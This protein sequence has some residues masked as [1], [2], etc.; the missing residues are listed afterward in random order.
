[1]SGQGRSTPDALSVPRPWSAGALLPPIERRSPAHCA[2]GRPGRCS[3][4]GIDRI[5]VCECDL[6]QARSLDPAFTPLIVGVHW[7]SLPWGQEDPSRATLTDIGD[8]DAAQDEFTRERSMTADKL[9]ERY[10]DRI[11][12]T[13]DARQAL[14]LVLMAAEDPQTGPALARGTVPAAVEAAYPLRFREAG[15]ALG[16]APAA[17]G[18]DQEGFCPAW[19]ITTWTQAAHDTTADGNTSS[20]EFSDQS[21]PGLQGTDSR[22]PGVLGGAWWDAARD[23]AL[24]PL[25][26]LSFWSMKRRA[27]HVGES[28]VHDLLVGLQ[29]SIPRARVHLMG[30]SFG[31]IV[32]CAAVAGPVADD[33]LVDRAPRAV[34]SLFLVQGAMSL[35]SFADTIPHGRREPG[36]Y[37]P[38]L[39]SPSLVS[40]PVVTTRSRHDRAVGTFFP[41]AARLGQDLTLAPVDLPEYGAVGAFGIQ[42]LAAVLTTS[43]DVMPADTD[44]DF[45]PGCVHNIDASNVICHGTGPSGAHSDITHPQIAHLL[46][47][48]ALVSMTRPKKGV[49]ATCREVLGSPEQDEAWPGRQ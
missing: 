17:P 3:G 37:Y 36:F 48:A 1:M 44:Y 40:G 43:H 13:P 28:G 8:P 42:G 14:N 31:C 6:N 33:V 21:V 7:P 49:P 32:V 19:T 15:L 4:L 39:R 38:A 18:S 10:A 5:R 23:A 25:R 24:M 27:R 47:Q 22:Q 41:L 35:W 2:S 20:D 45:Q 29:Y 34:E 30:L 9:L 46:W 26:Q 16:G 12:D 11:A